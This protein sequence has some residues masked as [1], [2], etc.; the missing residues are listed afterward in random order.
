MLPKQQQAFIII[1]LT[2]NLNENELRFL[3]YVDIHLLHMSIWCGNP[4]TFGCSL[5]YN[6]YVAVGGAEQKF[7]K[8]LCLWH[9][10]SRKYI[11]P[12]K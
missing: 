5:H 6:V 9:V 4:L 10:T 1:D 2:C 12:F 7:L 11:L 8:L 3:W